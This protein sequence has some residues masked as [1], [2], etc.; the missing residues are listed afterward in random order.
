MAL[1]ID[2]FAAWLATQGEGTVGT[3]LFKLSRPSSPTACLTLSATGGYPPE[4]Y[5]V[6][7]HPTIQ[8]V[9]RATTPNGA[10]AKAYS[11]FNRLPRKGGLTMA[12]LHAF[13]VEKTSSPAYIGEEQAGNQTC[14]LA[15]FNVVFDL[16]RPSS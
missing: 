10:I 6:R 13:T 1:L 4:L 8:V 14:H 16:R 7:E 3:N 12:T 11:V 5:G 9:A 2:E 15:S